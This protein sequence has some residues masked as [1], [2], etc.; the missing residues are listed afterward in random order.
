MED[1]ILGF[2]LFSGGDT[3]TTVGTLLVVLLVALAT[4]LLSRLA[5]KTTQ[6]ILGRLHE[7]W[8][9]HHHA[10]GQQPLAQARVVAHGVPQVEGER[11]HGDAHLAEDSLKV[12]RAHQV[13][14]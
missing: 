4:F 11:S 7:E 5:R 9:E 14:D 1:K 10:R 6:G 2:P 3:Q 13:L 8:A 12:G